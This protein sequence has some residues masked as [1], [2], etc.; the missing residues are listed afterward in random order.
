MNAKFYGKNVYI[1]MK[2]S[3]YLIV[4]TLTSSTVLDRS[5]EGQYHCL[6]S[7][8]ESEII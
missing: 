8:D 5:D 4:L 6:V 7:N 2:M 1:C 3:N